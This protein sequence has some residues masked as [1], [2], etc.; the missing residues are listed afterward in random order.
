M[1]EWLK[2]LLAAQGSLGF[3]DTLHTLLGTVPQ[4]QQVKDQQNPLGDIMAIAGTD[5]KMNPVMQMTPQ[6]QQQYGWT[7]DQPNVKRGDKFLA[8]E[9]GHLL[10]SAGTKNFDLTS[11]LFESQEEDL[12]DEEVNEKFADL[13]QQS[14]QFLRDPK[15]DLSKLNEKQA[16]ITNI[17]LQQPI[18]AQHPINQRRILEQI[19]M[20]QTLKR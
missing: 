5:Q 10:T 7:S 13:F 12:N 8:H 4:Y 18:Y 19:L 6:M 2:A 14:I 3:A 20:G 17:L 16:I 11:R 9:F 15:A 1:P